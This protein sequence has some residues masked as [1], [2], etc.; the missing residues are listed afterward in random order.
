MS[1]ASNLKD[2]ATGM[3]DAELEAECEAQVAGAY[4]WAHWTS[5]IYSFGKCLRFWTKYPRVLPLFVYSDHG[6]GLH[7]HLFQ[8]EL[9]SPAKVHFTWHPVKEQ[10]HKDIADKKVIQIIHPWISYRRLQGIT[11]SKRP[12]GTLAFFMHGTTAV[13]WE[14]HDSEEYFEKLRELPGK[15]QPVV[16]CLHMSDIKAGLHKKLRQHGF[17]I[18]T[19]GNTLST[20]F[21]DRFYDLVKNYSYA[22]APAWGSY[23]AYCVELGVPYF[24]LGERPVLVNIADPNL[25]MGVT[26][27]YWD[28]YHEELAKKAEALFRAPVDRVSDEQRAFVEPMLGFGS[29]LNRWQVSWIL[30]REFFRNWRQWR[31]IFKPLLFRFLNELGRIPMISRL[32]DLSLRKIIRRIRRMFQRDALP[33]RL[34]ITAKASVI[35]LLGNEQYRAISQLDRY[36]DGEL[37]FQGY[38]V[39]FTDNL[40]L[41]GMLD[42][43]FVR[44]NYKFDCQSESP[45][46]IDCGANIGLSALYF[47]SQYPNAVIHAF[48]PDPAAYEKLVANMEANGF[49]DVFTYKEAVWIEDGELVFETDGSWGGHI[50]DDASSAGVTVKARKLDGLLDKHVDFLK[51]DIE[52]AESDVIMHTKELIAKNVERLFFEWHSLTGAPQRLGEILAYFEKQGFRYHIKEASNRETPFVYKPVSRMDSQL[53]VFLWK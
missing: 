7:S 28:S 21:V 52:G 18:V 14:G 43:I 29:R 49:K 10:R 20:N 9:E 19:A 33:V 24:H 48:E 42:E 30:W 13:K 26:P 51:M 38:S 11:R 15:F 53:D 35:E 41:F 34:P 40:A 17:P 39:R 50:G 3:T 23:A 22:T 8:H 37:V 5:E 6:V 32:L 46:I 36:K 31:A 1:T 25:P 44:E 16:L 47:K 2:M 27:Q 4:P 45:V 12:E